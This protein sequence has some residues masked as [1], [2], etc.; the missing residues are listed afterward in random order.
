MDFLSAHVVRLPK[1]AH[2][3]QQVN[4]AIAGRDLRPYEYAGSRWRG[5]DRSFGHLASS[6]RARTGARRP[7][8]TFH[9][10]TVFQSLQHAARARDYFR[11]GLEPSCDLDVRFTGN[12]G[13]YFD[14]FY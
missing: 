2:G 8:L 10:R 7:S 14:K 6:S 5:G 1:L 9:R 4:L 13:S 11:A 12:S 3:D